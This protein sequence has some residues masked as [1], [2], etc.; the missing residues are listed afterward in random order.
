MTAMPPR[1][2]DPLRFCVNK[3]ASTEERQRWVATAA[4]FR[5]QRRG[6]VAGH[7]A[8]DWIAAELQIEAQIAERF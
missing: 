4:Y 6:F 8:E 7:E 1:N 3:P 2:F 5:A